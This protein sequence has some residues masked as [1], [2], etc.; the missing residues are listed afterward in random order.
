[1]GELE[2]LML[3]RQY[4]RVKS[5]LAFGGLHKQINYDP[6]IVSPTR[7]QTVKSALFSPKIESPHD[8]FQKAVQ[9]FNKMKTDASYGQSVIDSFSNVITSLP[10]NL[11]DNNNAKDKELLIQSLL[12]RAMTY[13]QQLSADPEELFEYEKMLSD[14]QKV[15]TLDPSCK[16]ALFLKACALLELG[17]LEN[18]KLAIDFF[19][20][21]TPMM[22]NEKIL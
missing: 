2:L 1:M 17:K 9:L 12:L 11:A 18:A 7:L 22:K 4:C 15:L 8:K 20:K 13:Q 5:E 14:V 21:C 6:I 3:M 19:Q 10:E 16:V